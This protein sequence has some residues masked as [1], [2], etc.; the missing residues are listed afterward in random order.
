MP[1]AEEEIRQLLYERHHI[2]LGDPPDFEV[3]T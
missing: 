3:Q 1:D 2:R